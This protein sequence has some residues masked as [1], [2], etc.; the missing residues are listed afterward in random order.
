MP[1]AEEKNKPVFLRRETT[2]T[3]PNHLKQH[4]LSKINAKC[5]LAI[6]VCFSVPQNHPNHTKTSKAPPFEFAPRQLRG[7]RAA[8]GS[9]GKKARPF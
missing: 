5:G 9:E 8:I 3:T 4:Y 1:T 7:S 2:P 6:Q